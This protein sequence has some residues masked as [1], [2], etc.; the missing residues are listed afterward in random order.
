MSPEAELRDPCNSDKRSGLI[1]GKGTECT[2]FLE[3][4]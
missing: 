4:I 3:F 2:N 1:E